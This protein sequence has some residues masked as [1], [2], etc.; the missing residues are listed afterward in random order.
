MVWVLILCLGVLFSSIGF[1]PIEIIQFAQVANGLLLP[2]IAGFLLWIVNKDSV[3]G[4]Y[5]NSR[6]QNLLGFLIC[7]AMLV[8]GAI[9]LLKVFKVL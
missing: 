9:S 6:M 8:L 2:I 7:F 5:K 3:L 1:K 4:S